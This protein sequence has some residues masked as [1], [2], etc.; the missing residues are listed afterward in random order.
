MA[1][2]L[3]FF[4]VVFGIFIFDKHIAN[5]PNQKTSEEIKNELFHSEII[6]DNFRESN[7]EVELN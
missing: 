7:F 2:G 5:K 6:P 3:G 4:L 1:I